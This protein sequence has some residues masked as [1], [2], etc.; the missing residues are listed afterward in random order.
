MFKMSI[1]EV[2]EGRQDICIETE[3]IKVSN[4]SS[5]LTWQDDNL[6]MVPNDF[7][8]LADFPQVEDDRPETIWNSEELRNQVERNCKSVDRKQNCSDRVV[9]LTKEEK[10]NSWWKDSGQTILQFFAKILGKRG[11]IG[12]KGATSYVLPTDNQPCKRVKHVSRDDKGHNRC[13]RDADGGIRLK[14]VNN[15][16][17][18]Y[19]A[20]NVYRYIIYIICEYTYCLKILK[21]KNLKL[22]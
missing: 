21:H 12:T 2:K 20:N 10:C 3:A 22:L 15:G 6:S 14:R 1:F 13:G 4:N 8:E 7:K 19:I 16:Y 5:F 11:G 9:E 17:I 18:G